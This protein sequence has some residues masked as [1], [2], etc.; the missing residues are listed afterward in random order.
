VPSALA[1]Q[2]AASLRSE[3]LRNMGMAD[4]DDPNAPPVAEF[5]DAAERRVRLGLLVGAVIQDNGLEVDRELVKARVDEICAP[6]D[7]PEQ[8]RKMYFQ[9]PQLIG[10]V[11]NMVL[12]EQVVAWLVDRSSVTTKQVSF[13]EL[14]DKQ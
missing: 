13:N 9:N 2:E 1:D 7:Q 14:M 12:E 4:D 10:Q 8:I 6:Y 11:E 3:S 5:R